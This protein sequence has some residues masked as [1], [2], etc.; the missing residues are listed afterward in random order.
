MR[1]LLLV[2]CTL[3]SLGC[4]PEATDAT[5]TMARS[6]LAVVKHCATHADGYR[7]CCLVIGHTFP[8][9]S[10]HGIMFCA[11][12]RGQRFSHW[13][14]EDTGADPTPIP[15]DGW[16]QVP[17]PGYGTVNSECWKDAGICWFPGREGPLVLDRAEDVVIHDLEGEGLGFAPPAS[18]VIDAAF[19]CYDHGDVTVCCMAIVVNDHSI[20]V[21]GD[22]LGRWTIVLSHEIDQRRPP[23]GA[24]Q[25]KVPGYGT[26]TA[27]CWDAEGVCRFEDKGQPIIV[28]DDD[29]YVG[30]GYP[31]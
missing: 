11:S 29:V 1:L 4:T 26:V 14:H 21:C 9:G 13:Y 16:S 22:N 23:D 31:F 2:M 19:E 10:E 8:D 27:E 15:S 17:V 3:L 6:E 30:Q 12:N 18:L 7:L 5:E 24:R 20:A 25:I 28:H